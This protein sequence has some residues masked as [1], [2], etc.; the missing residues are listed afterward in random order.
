MESISILLFK[1]GFS[2]QDIP[3]G[4]EPNLYGNNIFEFIL[5]AIDEHLVWK[6]GITV[7]EA[8]NN[9]NATYN[10]IRIR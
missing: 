3:H 10:V 4:Y 1:P 6:S 5:L 8:S 2:I 9:A 7:P